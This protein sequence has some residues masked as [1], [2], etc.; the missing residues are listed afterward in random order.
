MKKEKQVDHKNSQK[1]SDI[2]INLFKM[3]AMLSESKVRVLM[4]KKD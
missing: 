2:E 4:A 1:L 3:F